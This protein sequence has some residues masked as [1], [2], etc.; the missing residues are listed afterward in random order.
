MTQPTQ[1]QYEGHGNATGDEMDVLIGAYLENNMND[2]GE[3]PLGAM[4]S[5]LLVQ[6]MTK[7][8]KPY[9]ALSPDNI[10]GKVSVPTKNDIESIQVTE[11]N[12][13]DALDAL[14]KME[15]DLKLK[16]E[17]VLDS[18]DTEEKNAIEKIPS[19]PSPIINWKA[20]ATA[21]GAGFSTCVTTTLEA[22]SVA[23]LAK[24][25]L[26]VSAPIV[27]FKGIHKLTWKDSGW[28]KH[29]MNG[30]TYWK[31]E[32]GKSGNRR[33]QIKDDKTGKFFEVA[34]KHFWRAREGVDNLYNYWSRKQNFEEAKIFHKAQQHV[35]QIREGLKNN[36][37]SYQEN[38]VN[39]NQ[40]TIKLS[41]ETTSTTGNNENKSFNLPDE[42]QLL[43]QN[44]EPGIMY[45]V[46]EALKEL[47][48][49]GGEFLTITTGRQV[50]RTLANIDIKL[51]TGLDNNNNEINRI[52]LL[53][54]S[55]YKTSLVI[56]G[57][58]LLWGGDRIIIEAL[59]L[60]PK[61][62]PY[63]T[64]LQ[65]ISLGLRASYQLIKAGKTAMVEKD[66]TNK[67]KTFSWEL[68]KLVYAYTENSV[69]LE[70]E[71]DITKNNSLFWGL[72]K[73][74]S[75]HYGYNKIWKAVSGGINHLLGLSDYT[76]EEVVSIETD[77]TMEDLEKYFSN[78]NK[79]K[80]EN[81]S[82]DSMGEE[83]FNSVYQPTS[84]N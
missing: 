59:C 44:S 75:F 38:S 12:I 20:W 50:G 70:I 79:N 7:N 34:S 60:L 18:L 33:C 48:S 55:S 84:S 35:N 52:E 82:S 45:N 77:S 42:S 13:E 9:W 73:I 67:I 43:I 1:N 72:S 14:Q 19:P 61:F 39:F 22:I 53:K 4:L 62:K 15:H 64:T 16:E 6:Y 5:N 54:N 8:K 25:V 3:F 24:A 57:H 23:F 63:K 65:E 28:E 36:Y 2:S 76:D 83:L 27:I 32:C 68:T 41:S 46:K 56:L 21:G 11:E 40:E 17:E 49:E 80:N 26:I 71:R 47:K 51:L 29:S 78:E 30:R 74:T 58:L 66:N 31:R 69:L 37:K 10:T 81:E